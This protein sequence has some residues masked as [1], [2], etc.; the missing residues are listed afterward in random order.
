MPINSPVPPTP[1]RMGYIGKLQVFGLPIRVSAASL[2]A[3]QDIKN[4][5]VIDNRIDRSVYQ[6]GPVEVEGSISFP[7]LTT[8]VQNTFLNQ[9]WAFAMARDPNSGELIN[10]GDVIEEY[11]YQMSRTFKNCLVNTFSMEATYGD[12]V[13]ADMGLWGTFS[14]DGGNGTDPVDVSPARVLTWDQVRITSGSSAFNTCITRSFKININNNLARNYTFCDLTAQGA[15]HSLFA[16]NISTGKRIIEGEITFQGFAPT[17]NLASQNSLNTT[18]NENLTFNF[19][20]FTKT[21]HHVI[22]AYQQINMGMSLITST[23]NWF[24][25]GGVSDPALDS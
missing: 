15:P 13:K 19:N 22:Y 8:G 9:I 17:D 3:K 18:S 14:I 6:L 11:S 21:A 23:A 5:D 25:Y 20:G 10:R 2:N 24:A 12:Q 7:V 1:G 16:S 4:V